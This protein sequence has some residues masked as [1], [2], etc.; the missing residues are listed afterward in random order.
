M[1]STIL[2]LQQELKTTRDRIQLLEKENYQLKTGI[3]TNATD[4]DEDATMKD[5]S[6][7]LNEC[8]DDDKLAAVNGNMNYSTQSP[9]NEQNLNSLETIDENTCLRN[10]NTTNATTTA[11]YNGNE[12][13]STEYPHEGNGG[14]IG[15]K[16]RTVASRK[17]NYECDSGMD[18]SNLN[19]LNTPAV[20]AAAHNVVSSP[21]TLPPKKSKLRVAPVRRPSVQTIDENEMLISSNNHGNATILDNAVDGMANEESSSLNDNAGNNEGVNDSVNAGGVAVAQRIMTRRRS[22]RLNGG[23]NG[24]DSNH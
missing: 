3:N 13:Q 15:A 10:N 4:D 8:Q 22:V 2:F 18:T 1:Q 16:L 14:A 12:E 5:E 9:A 11:Y 19:S 17:R 20:A 21:R 7:N 23:S 24:G 6:N